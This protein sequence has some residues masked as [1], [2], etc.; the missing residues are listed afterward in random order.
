MNAK[1]KAAVARRRFRPKMAKTASRTLVV[2]VQRSVSEYIVEESCGILTPTVPFRNAMI[3]S[4]DIM[5][6]VMRASAEEALR[7]PSSLGNMCLGHQSVRMSILVGAPG[8]GGLSGVQPSGRL[9]AP[10]FKPNSR[11]EEMARHGMM[12]AR[13]T[14][15]RPEE[16]LLDAILECC[17][18]GV[19]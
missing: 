4:A 17:S 2:Y 14:V 3:A 13:Q 9:G 5:N 8:S 18:S 10:F 11:I 12:M 19:L 16:N 6:A 1:R 15:T 7:I